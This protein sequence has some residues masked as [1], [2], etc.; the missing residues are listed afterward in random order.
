MNFIDPPKGKFDKSQ[1]ITKS[2]PYMG[3]F[4][5]RPSFHN[6]A[7][8]LSCLIQL[9]LNETSHHVNVDHSD[10]NFFAN[11]RFP[12]CVRIYVDHFNFRPS[13]GETCEGKREGDICCRSVVSLTNDCGCSSEI[14]VSTRLSAE[15][16]VLDAIS[17]PTCGGSFLLFWACMPRV[18]VILHGRRSLRFTSIGGRLQTERSRLDTGGLPHSHQGQRVFR[19]HPS[20]S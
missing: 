9:Q 7:L 2:W 15:Q 12:V 3:L 5:A 14:S 19:D 11:I 8:K 18:V 6:S 4:N 16:T 1:Q 17:R 10:L 13:L 20:C